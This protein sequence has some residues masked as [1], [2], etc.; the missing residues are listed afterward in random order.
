MR[1]KEEWPSEAGRHNVL[2]LIHRKQAP[3]NKK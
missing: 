3:D 1:T 2:M